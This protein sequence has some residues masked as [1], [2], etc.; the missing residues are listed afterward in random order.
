MA[1][2]LGTMALVTI[3]SSCAP[4]AEGE[5]PRAGPAQSSR[6]TGPTKTGAP[7]P[8]TPPTNGKSR[9]PSSAAS[10]ASLR[11]GSEPASPAPSNGGHRST[12]SAPVSDPPASAA[13]D[14]PRQA[15]P[16]PPGKEAPPLDPRASFKA[17]KLL[18]RAHILYG[19]GEYDKAEQAIKEAVT[20]YP[21]MAEANLMLGKIF[22]IRG[23]ATRDRAMINSARL[24]F[25]MARALDPEMREPAVLLELF[26]LAPPE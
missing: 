7:A 16:I 26:L 3:V 21:F 15:Y 22:L 5:P 12:G 4:S 6:V 1:R 8:A 14:P 11:G 18:Q 10:T 24:M 2:L 25:E 9:R 23:S 19:K 13:V 17:K 20:M